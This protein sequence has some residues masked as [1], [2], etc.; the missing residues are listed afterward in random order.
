M[1]PAGELGLET[2]GAPGPG[3]G[4]RGVQ[5]VVGVEAL[6]EQ[7]PQADQG[8]KK[9]VIEGMAL[10]GGQLE[11]G[12]GRQQLDKEPEQLGGAGPLRRVVLQGVFLEDI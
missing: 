11:Q 10:E 5:A 6:E 4:Q 8:R 12:P 7:Q 9:P 1:Q 2:V 3:V